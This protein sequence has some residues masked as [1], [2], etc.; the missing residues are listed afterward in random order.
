MA[1]TT[2][3]ILSDKFHTELFL[4]MC[5]ELL[6]DSSVKVT[7]ENLM[8]ILKRGYTDPFKIPEKKVEWFQDEY[9]DIVKFRNFEEGDYIII[10]GDYTL[11]E[12]DNLYLLPKYRYNGRLSALNDELNSIYQ[13]FREYLVTYKG[14]KQIF[15]KELAM[16]LFENKKDV[17]ELR[18]EIFNILNCMDISTLEKMRMENILKGMF[19]N[20]SNK[21]EVLMILELFYRAHEEVLNSDK[22]NSTTA[23]NE[24]Y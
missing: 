12:A 13:P 19:E 15:S 16:T 6:N 14:K 2:N 11:T 5:N 1:T 3:F 20:I 21:N 10:R 7:R 22:Y 18:N 17:I 8:L 4:G 24:V 9:P 23:E